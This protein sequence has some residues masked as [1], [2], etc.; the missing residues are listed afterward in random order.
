MTAHALPQSDATISAEPRVPH[1]DKVIAAKTFH[2]RTGIFLL[3]DMSLICNQT[4]RGSHCHYCLAPGLFRDYS[5]PFSEMVCD[6]CNDTV[7]SALSLMPVTKAK[8]FF[9]NILSP[10]A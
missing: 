2:Q 1:H 9:C 3:R 7:F 5:K 8:S 6:H 4:R 10:A